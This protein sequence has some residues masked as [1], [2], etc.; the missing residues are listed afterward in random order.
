MRRV[1]KIKAS[2]LHFAVLIATVVGL[3]LI[4]F[5]L[6]TKTH[7]FFKTQSRDFI[8][9]VDAVNF[10][11]KSALLS[12]EL[13]I[14]DSINYIFNGHELSISKSFLGAFELYKTTDQKSGFSKIALSG[15]RYKKDFPSI[16]LQ[17]N[18]LPLVVSGETYIEGTTYLPESGVKSSAISGHHYTGGTLIYGPIKKASKNFPSL[19]IAWQ[20][21]FEK[22]L[23]FVPSSKDK[24]AEFNKDISNSFF[25]TPIYL[26]DQRPILLDNT[27]LGHIIIKSDKQI[28]VSSFC[29]LDQVTVIAPIV[30]IEEG[31][32]GS[33]H[34]LASDS[35]VID[36]KVFLEYPSS[37]SVLVKQKDSEQQSAIV[38][39]QNATVK[40]NIIYIEEQQEE[41]SSNIL[42][43]K[44]AVFEGAI[45]A[46]GA[47]EIKGE[48]TGSIYTHYFVAKEFGNIYRN[49]IYSGRIVTK[50]IKDNFC[51]LPLANYKKG[52][53]KWLY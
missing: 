34:V 25:N 7:S 52:I 43:E 50:D 22:L 31:F 26:Y 27:Y 13:Q 41:L 17:D 53:A 15:A 38:I 9:A 6:I 47:V 5:L 20:E 28:T 40:G 46:Q 42:I 45:Y 16:Y 19:D 39:N 14:S 1:K 11:L 44:D 29:N 24:V 18:F 33:V 8:E 4:S 23:K 51:G 32:R 35:I 30:K 2:A 3:L 12:N 36:K 37:L 48:V 21:Y 10:G 49:H